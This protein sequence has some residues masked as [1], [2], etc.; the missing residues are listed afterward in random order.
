MMQYLLYRKDIAL[1]YRKRYICYRIRYRM[2]CDIACDKK[3]IMIAAALIS[4]L[5]EHRA[6][7]A[8]SD[9]HW[10]ESRC[11]RRRD[12]GVTVARNRHLEG[13]DV[14][15][16]HPECYITKSECYITILEMLHNNCY[17]THVI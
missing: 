9:G 17:I 14:L 15:Y 13:W 4:H 2:Q 12:G 8:A 5:S 16:N 6:S 7:A 3:I 11:H 10:Q 1:R